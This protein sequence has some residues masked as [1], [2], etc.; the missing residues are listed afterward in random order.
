MKTLRVIGLSTLVLGAMS[1]LC[2]SAQ[3]FYSPH[4]G[5]DVVCVPESQTV[6]EG[7]TAYFLAYGGD[8][9]Y[10]WQTEGHTYRDRGSRFSHVFD[11]RGTERVTVKSDGESDTCRV[12]VVERSYNYYPPTFTHAFPPVTVAAT[13]IPSA[14]PNTGFPP[15]SS[16][17][18]AFA[19]VLLFG[20]GLALTP[21][22]KKAITTAGR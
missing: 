7:E 2:A 4:Y 11:D 8:G 21:Y 5:D 20:V 10:D 17:S 14:M 1:P 19:V 6:V 12:T 22:A 9:D 13:Y 18:L 15:V 16:A 3:Y